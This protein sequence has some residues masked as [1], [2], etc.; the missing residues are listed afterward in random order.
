LGAWEGSAAGLDLQ[1]D[2]QSG[3]GLGKLPIQPYLLLPWTSDLA[4]FEAVAADF[5]TDVWS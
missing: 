3:F 2:V 4:A 5:G 1:V